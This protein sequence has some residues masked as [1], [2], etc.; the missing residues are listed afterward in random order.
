MYRSS[1]YSSPNPCRRASWGNSASSARNFSARVRSAPRDCMNI[2]FAPK[3]VR[4]GW[5]RAPHRAKARAGSPPTALSCRRGVRRGRVQIFRPPPFLCACRNVRL[6]RHISR[7]PSASAHPIFPQGRKMSPSTSPC[8]ALPQKTHSS[9][10][11]W[12]TRR[13]GRRCAPPR[14]FRPRQAPPRGP[15]AHVHR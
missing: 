5:L 3:K 13:R 15:R 11:R 10:P 8:P 12:R 2:S 4:R 9:F 7:S 6:S 1:A 14:T